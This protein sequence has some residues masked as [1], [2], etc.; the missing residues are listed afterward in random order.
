MQ[1]LARVPQN[2]EKELE[3]VLL[4]LQDLW[5][6]EWQLGVSSLLALATSPE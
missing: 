4:Q 2:V 1:Y 3:S 5:P 6:V